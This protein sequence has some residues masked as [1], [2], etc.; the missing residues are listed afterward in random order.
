MI[1]LHGLP[2]QLKSKNPKPTPNFLQNLPV[3]GRYIFA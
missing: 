3:I 1:S 2:T